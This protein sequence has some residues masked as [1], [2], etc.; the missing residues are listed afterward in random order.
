MAVQQRSYCDGPL[1]IVPGDPSLHKPVWTQEM[2][3]C[4]SQTLANK[5]APRVQV[6]L[7]SVWFGL[8]LLYVHRG[9]MA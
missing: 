9:E 5:A 2:W 3:C 6:S 7:K 4:F 8:V 1:T